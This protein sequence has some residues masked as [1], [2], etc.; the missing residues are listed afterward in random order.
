MEARSFAK[1]SQGWEAC[2]PIRWKCSS[3]V[4][5]LSFGRVKLISGKTEPWAGSRPCALRC[6]FAMWT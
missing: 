2:A 3:R 4:L 1:V 5:P 6:S